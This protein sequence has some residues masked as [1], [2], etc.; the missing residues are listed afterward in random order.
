MEVEQGQGSLMPEIGQ[1]PPP[2]HTQWKGGGGD[3]PPFWEPSRVL[4]PDLSDSESERVIFPFPEGYIFNSRVYLRV[5]FF[6]W[7]PNGSQSES[8]RII[9]TNTVPGTREMSDKQLLVE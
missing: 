9:E 5:V 3:R 7:Q 4:Y 6:F 8:C 2:Q 1:G